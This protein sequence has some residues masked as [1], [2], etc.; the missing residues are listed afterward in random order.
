MSGMAIFVATAF[1]II[2]NTFSL[3]SAHGCTNS[4]STNT[5]HAS[6]GMSETSGDTTSTTKPRALTSSTQIS[7][8]DVAI[9]TLKHPSKD[10][11]CIP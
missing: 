7:I 2:T 3:S 8:V 6:L 11:E 5:N 9:K 10:G 4:T 1:I